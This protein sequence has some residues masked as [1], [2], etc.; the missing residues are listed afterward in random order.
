MALDRIDRQRDHLGVAS[1]G[2]VHEASPRTRLCGA[3]QR[4]V[5]GMDGENGPGAL[6]PV[7]E[8]DGPIGGLG[9]EPGCRGLKGKRGPR[10][11]LSVAEGSRIVLITIDHDH[12]HNRAVTARKKAFR[13]GGSLDR[14][15]KPKGPPW[16]MSDRIVRADFA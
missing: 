14:R 1:L 3:D 15:F 6:L 16:T 5:R 8:V 11:C 4:V 13:S 9:S 2:L 7:Q 12:E 10:S